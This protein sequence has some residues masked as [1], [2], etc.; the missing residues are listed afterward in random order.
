MALCAA[1]RG[2]LATVAILSQPNGKATGV[3]ALTPTPLTFLLAA[4]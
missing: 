1:G 4:L 2:V 3:A